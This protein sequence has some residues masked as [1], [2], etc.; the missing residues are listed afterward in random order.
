MT[1]YAENIPRASNS[2]PVELNTAANTVDARTKNH[3]TLIRELNVMRAGVVG[4]V[5]VVRVCRELSRESIDTL[6]EGR[7]AERLAIGANSIFLRGNEVGNVRV[8]EALAFGT[9]QE[10]SIN[11]FKRSCLL[12]GVDCLDDVVDLVQ[13][14]LDSRRNHQSKRPFESSI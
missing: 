9:L 13:E 6:D 7:Y 5:Q 4:R 3:G 12:E 11:V 10:L 1:S 2:T 14:P 8:R